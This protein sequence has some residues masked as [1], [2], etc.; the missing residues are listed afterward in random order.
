LSLD[1]SLSMPHPWMHV[2]KESMM[3]SISPVSQAGSAFASGSA[4]AASRP[5]PPAQ[6]QAAV[7]PDHDGDH[8]APG[9]IDVKA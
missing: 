1:R 8:D 9:R 2:A 4:Q 6:P 5:V 3:S 7:D